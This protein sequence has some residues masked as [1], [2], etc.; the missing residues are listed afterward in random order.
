MSFQNGQWL[1]Y[2]PKLA[3]I[4]PALFTTY[5]EEHV[6]TIETWLYD[7]SS[8]GG[9]F[10]Y[11][12][13]F[14]AKSEL[15]TTLITTVYEPKKEFIGWRP[16]PCTIQK[17][18]CTSLER[19][20]STHLPDMW[21]KGVPLG[22]TDVKWPWCKTEIELETPTSECASSAGPATVY[23][24]R[25][26]KPRDMCATKPTDLPTAPKNGKSIPL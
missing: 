6:T 9:A 16:D 3:S 14:V 18:D 10:T 7:S 21:S 15:T 19:A 22:I 24:W 11:P 23:Y 26:S 2:P 1:N 13:R 5:V 4:S 25:D 12:E 17:D 8:V 20:M